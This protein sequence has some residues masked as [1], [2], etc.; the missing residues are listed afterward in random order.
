M[1]AILMYVPGLTERA[2]ASR[3]I[4]RDSSSV[5][6]TP[7][8]RVNPWCLVFVV[9]MYTRVHYSLTNTNTEMAARGY[10]R[11]RSGWTGLGFAIRACAEPAQANMGFEQPAD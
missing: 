6:L 4:I 8:S 7:Q 10:L 3:S 11:S 9:F 2:S 1:A 5:N